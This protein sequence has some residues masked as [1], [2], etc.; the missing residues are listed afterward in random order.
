MKVKQD[1]K[2]A[3][4]MVYNVKEKSKL[5]QVGLPRIHYIAS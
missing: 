3:L 1:V 2:Y 4:P 5:D